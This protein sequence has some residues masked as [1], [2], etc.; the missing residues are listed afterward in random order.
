MAAIRRI[1]VSIAVACFFVMAV[2]GA[3]KGRSP[4]TCCWRAVC[5]AVIAYLVVALAGRAVLAIVVE[6]MVSSRMSDFNENDD[7]EDIG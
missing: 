1:A 3:I 7:I 5:G 4:A 6:A 2:V